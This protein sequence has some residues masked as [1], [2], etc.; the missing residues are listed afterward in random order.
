MHLNELIV[1]YSNTSIYKQQI[2]LRPYF[3]YIEFIWRFIYILKIIFLI[4]LYKMAATTMIWIYNNYL[5][6][7]IYI[8]FDH[9]IFSMY[10]YYHINDW[11]DFIRQWVHIFKTIS[12]WS[13]FRWIIQ[14]KGINPKTWVICFV[15]LLI[16][17]YIL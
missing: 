12:H 14:I 17:Y 4:W 13:R 11:P 5:L 8:L 15:Y 7:I 10:V 9:N 3:I 1:I 2:T 6:R 16:R